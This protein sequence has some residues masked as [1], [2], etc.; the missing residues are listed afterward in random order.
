MEIWIDSLDEGIISA[1]KDLGLLHG[2]TTNPS[3]LSKSTMDPRGVISKLLEIQDGPVAVQVM[4]ETKEVIIQEASILKEISDRVL[5]KI[6]VVPEGV[7]A[8]Q[9]LRDNAT[10][11]LGTAVLSFR[12]SFLAI[13]GGFT[14]IAPYIGRFVDEGKDPASLL[15]FLVKLKGSFRS[16][17][18]IMAAGIR[19]LDHL[20]LSAE[21]GVDAATLPESVAR[22]L[23]TI[24]E[25][26]LKAL[27]QFQDD[28][29]SKRDQLFNHSDLYRK[30]LEI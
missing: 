18:K 19:S 1:F 11:A 25:G 13:S 28:F 21:L 29:G 10:S 8:M 17:A 23:L 3:I 26:A 15:N 9:V 24:P 22:Q 7:A 12:Q 4:G 16:D 27:Y 20:F 5:P 2:V 6:P 14:Y 30:C